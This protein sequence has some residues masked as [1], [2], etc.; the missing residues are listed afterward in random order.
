MPSRMDQL[1]TV[2]RGELWREQPDR[3]QVQIPRPQ[4][5]QELR[6]T[7]RRASGQD[8]LVGN[9]LCEMKHALAVREHRGASLLE[10]ELPPVDLRQVSEQLG[11]D[12]VAAPHQFPNPR[13]QLGVGQPSE[14]FRHDSTSWQWGEVESKNNMAFRNALERLTRPVLWVVSQFATRIRI[15]RAQA[16][17]ERL[18][19][20]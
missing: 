19:G 11:L 20:N 12:R 3:R 8:P 7:P 16:K 13:D 9:S 18:S 4:S 14:R 5:I 10:I 17:A 1:R 2:V 6:M 15:T